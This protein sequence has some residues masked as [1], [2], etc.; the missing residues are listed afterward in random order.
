MELALLIRHH[1]M[2]S[3]VLAPPLYMDH[4]VNKVCQLAFNFLPVQSQLD[5][6]TANLLQKCIASEKSSCYLFLST[7]RRQLDELFAQ[8]DIAQINLSC[9][10]VP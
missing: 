7:A 8:F 4:C 5:I 6:R 1:Q 2:V 10:E 3:L 9:V